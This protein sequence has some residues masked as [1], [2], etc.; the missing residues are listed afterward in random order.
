MHNTVN[1]LKTL[2]YTLK[3]MDF[4]HMCELYLNKAV[5][6]KK[7]EQVIKHWYF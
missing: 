4:M 3:Y 6:F 2:V 7:E 1:V 5:I